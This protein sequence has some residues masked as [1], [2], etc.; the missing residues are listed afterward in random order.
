MK[1][2]L[3]CCEVARLNEVRV[4]E[5]C[6]NGDCQGK[7]RGEVGYEGCGCHDGGMLTE[8]S[9]NRCRGIVLVVERQQQ[10]DAITS[11]TPLEIRD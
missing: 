8:V 4:R 11:A 6:R 3:L 2:V 7:S 5:G 9:P 1:K 10:H